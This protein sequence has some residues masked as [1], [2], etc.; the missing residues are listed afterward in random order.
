MRELPKVVL[1]LL[2]LQGDLESSFLH[3]ALHEQ[4]YIDEEN[5]RIIKIGM[6]HELLIIINEITDVHQKGY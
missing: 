4:I 6:G 2:K 3:L 5:E 1:D